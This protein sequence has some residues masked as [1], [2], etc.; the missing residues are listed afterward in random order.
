MQTVPKMHNF[1]VVSLLHIICIR[2]VSPSTDTFLR[3]TERVVP[4]STLVRIHA[5]LSIFGWAT[6]GS[7]ASYEVCKYAG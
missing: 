5:A 2:L 1:F 7:V 6:C 4:Q 3:F